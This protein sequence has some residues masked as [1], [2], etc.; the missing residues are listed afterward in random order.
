MGN[1]YDID[2]GK[3]SI[4]LIGKEV[5]MGNR[6]F[7]GDKYSNGDAARPVFYFQD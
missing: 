6:V 1:L 4:E 7:P 3:A 5:K 2:L